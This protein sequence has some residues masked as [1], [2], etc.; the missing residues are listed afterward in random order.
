LPLTTSEEVRVA[1]SPGTV[2]AE[3]AND[4]MR[5]VVVEDNDDSR[6]MLES[7]LH[8]DGYDVRTARDGQEGLKA[9]IESQPAVAFV[10]IGLPVLD[11]YQVARQVRFRSELRTVYLVALTG[12]GRAEDRQAVLDAGFDEHLVKP[13]RSQ[14]LVRVLERVRTVHEQKKD[15][16]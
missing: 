9:I 2:P 13:L 7:L 4:T 12:Y 16:G 15:R 6:T 1:E 11:G 14:E 5:I 8:L 10:D 3:S